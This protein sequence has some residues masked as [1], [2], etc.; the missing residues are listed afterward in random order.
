MGRP[1][2]ITSVFTFEGHVSISLI[3]LYM[4]VR[5]TLVS[6]YDHCLIDIKCSMPID[7]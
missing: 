4:V 6:V 1:G 3:K 5:S 7:L 2:F